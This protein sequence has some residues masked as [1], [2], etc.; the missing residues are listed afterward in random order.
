MCIALIG[1]MDR[2]ERQYI[3][4]AVKVGVNLKVFTKSEA[5]MTSKIGFVDAVVIF[6]NKV[7][8]KAKKEVVNA[9]KAR[10]IRVF[11]HHSCGICS[12]RDCLSC[13]KNEKEV[14]VYVRN[15]NK[16]R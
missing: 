1:G 4:E 6:T 14:S 9:A 16:Q 3:E 15:G 8:H 11:M 7:S 12:L 10:N 5:N 2:L 13:I